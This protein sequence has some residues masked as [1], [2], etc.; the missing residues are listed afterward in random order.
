M[1]HSMCVEARRRFMGAGSLLSPGES[2][3]SNSGLW[4]CQYMP[5]PTELSHWPIKYFYKQSSN[6]IMFIRDYW[7]QRD[8]KK[9]GSIKTPEDNR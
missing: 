7:G 1:F 9:N 8:W 5:L 6:L 2:Q 3:G 4:A